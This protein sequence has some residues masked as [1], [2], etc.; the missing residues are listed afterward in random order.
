MTAPNDFT[1]AVTINFDPASGLSLDAGPLSWEL[2]QTECGAF[3][4]LTDEEILVFQQ[5]AAEYLWNW[6]STQFGLASISIRPCRT[7]SPAIPG[8]YEGRGPITNYVRT[9]WY[10]AI[11]GGAYYRI[12]CATC[13]E[14]CLCDSPK[15]LVLPGPIIEI[16]EVKVDGAVVPSTSYRVDNYHLLVRTDGEAWPTTQDMTLATTEVG[17]F[18]ITYKRGIPVPYG[19]QVAAGRLACE[20]AKAAKNDP[21]CALPQR[22]QSITRQGVTV[23]VLDSFDDVDTGRTGIW[24]IDSWVAS[25]TKPRRPGAVYSVDVGRPKMRSRTS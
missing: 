16:T 23:A 21:S 24:L 18:E 19:G 11:I 10:P 1:E 8:T 3:D 14:T 9:G 13:G 5:M 6:T 15:S 12:Y 22:V 2:I 20:L 7:T 17:T 4:G 25:V